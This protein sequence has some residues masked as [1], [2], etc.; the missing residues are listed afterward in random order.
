VGL[1]LALA[2]VGPAVGTVL[3]LGTLR[4][5][6]PWLRGHASVGL[7]LFIALATLLSGLAVMPT[8][9]QS[10]LAGWAFGSGLG[11]AAVMLAYT[12][13][14]AIAA[15]LTRRVSGDKVVR[16][17]DAQPR[18]QA[19]RRALI[20]AGFGRSL[21]IVTLV[22][23]PPNCPFA[24]TNVVMASVRVP[25][26]AYLLGTA[27]G[28]APR[29]LAVVCI[30]TELRHLGDLDFSSR[31]LIARL[32]ASAALSLLALLVIGLIARRALRRVT[33]P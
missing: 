10:L 27:L 9:I 23:L 22:R 12:A 17:I 4:E 26:A 30:G 31:Y 21:L 2:S 1:L 7:P 16:L 6:G 8:Y 5:L 33:E 3:I 25:W 32:L 24:L 11:F 28:L 14:A 20:G 13:A 15:G 29:T 19:V 18:W